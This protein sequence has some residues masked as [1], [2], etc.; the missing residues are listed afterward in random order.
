[1]VTGGSPDHRHATY[2]NKDPGCSRTTDPDMVLGSS[3]GLDATLVLGDKQAFSMNPFLTTLSSLTSTHKPFHP[4]SPPISPPDTHSSKQHLPSTT[5]HGAGQPVDASDRQA[6]PW[7][8][9]LPCEGLSPA[10]AHDIR[11]SCGCFRQAT[12]FGSEIS[13]KDLVLEVLSPASSMPGD[14]WALRVWGLGTEVRELGN[15]PLKGR[16]GSQISLLHNYPELRDF[17]LL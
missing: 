1:M 10:W 3:P 11:W 9:L 8:P 15:E 12:E 7:G 14:D 6:W 2:V 17:A 16:M 13:P 5:R 4:Y